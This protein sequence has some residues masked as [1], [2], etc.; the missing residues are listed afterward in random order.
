MEFRASDFLL[1]VGSFSQA[2]LEVLGSYGGP[3]GDK[4]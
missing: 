1:E 2:N 4:H 3:A